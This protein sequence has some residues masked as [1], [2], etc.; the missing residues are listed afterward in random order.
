MLQESKPQLA[1]V[2][3]VSMHFTHADAV[4]DCHVEQVVCVPVEMPHAVMNAEM[5]ASLHCAAMGPSGIA[6][7]VGAKPLTS[8]C[9]HE[10][11]EPASQAPASTDA[12]MR[13]ASGGPPSSA[14]AL[15]ATAAKAS[16]N[17]TPTTL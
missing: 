2:S 15:G 6:S 9:S 11:P 5:S 1:A 10:R 8:H 16:T 12:S 3:G 17:D 13:P 14:R 7:V 4:D